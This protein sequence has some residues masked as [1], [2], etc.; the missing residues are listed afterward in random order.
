MRLWAVLVTGLTAL[1]GVGLKSF[2]GLFI[3]GQFE[4]TASTSISARRS[5]K[6]P[7]FEMLGPMSMDPSFPTGTYMKKLTLVTMSFLPRPMNA[8]AVKMTPAAIQG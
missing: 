1:T 7:G 6:S 2:T 5:T 3:C 4:T 8:M